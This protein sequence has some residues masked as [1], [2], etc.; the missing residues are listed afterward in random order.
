MN[1]SKNYF[2]TLTGSLLF[3]SP[4][5][6]NSSALNKSTYDFSNVNI[7]E[8]IKEKS[9]LDD[10]QKIIAGFSRKRNLEGKIMRLEKKIEMIDEKIKG[11]PEKDSLLL[12]KQR[13]KMFKKKNRFKK[14]LRSL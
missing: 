6:V 9:I 7:S 3:L 10:S 12:R 1:R 11:I 14:E 4:L 2:L 8:E 13:T 5:T